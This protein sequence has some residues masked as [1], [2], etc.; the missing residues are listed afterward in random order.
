[1]LN[2]AYYAITSVVSVPEYE[3]HLQM[4]CLYYETLEEHK[5]L[6]KIPRL[7][8]IFYDLNVYLMDYVELCDDDDIKVTDAKNDH[9]FPVHIRNDIGKFLGMFARRYNKVLYDFEIYLEHCGSAHRTYTILDFGNY[10]GVNG[11]KGTLDADVIL[12][13]SVIYDAFVAELD[14]KTR[15]SLTGRLVRV[16]G[17]QSRQGSSARS[18]QKRMQAAERQLARQ[19]QPA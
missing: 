17:I 15:R 19:M 10:I 5:W 16:E 2:G 1:M 9:M 12:Y 4:L 8:P 3:T 6:F 13:N 11:V 18:P 14:S 7:Y